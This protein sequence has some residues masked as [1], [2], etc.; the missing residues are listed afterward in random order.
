MLDLC[1]LSWVW[2][3]WL[4]SWRLIC[5]LL[6]WPFQWCCQVFTYPS[7]SVFVHNPREVSFPPKPAWQ[8]P[9]IFGSSSGLH[10]THKVADTRLRFLLPLKC[11]AP[12]HLPPSL[13][14]KMNGTTGFCF[15]KIDAHSYNQWK[16]PFKKFL[17]VGNYREIKDWFIWKHSSVRMIHREEVI[18]SLLLKWKCSKYRPTDLNFYLKSNFYFQQLFCT[19]AAKS[20]VN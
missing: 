16:P 8:S 20:L 7:T 13:A 18:L 5:K 17:N 14:S 15:F 19:E 10:W 3:C 9:A 12:R 6:L 4:H 1:W 11:W 2:R